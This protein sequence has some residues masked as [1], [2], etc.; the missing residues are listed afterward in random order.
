MQ[1]APKGDP[2]C[3][4]LEA[5]G[6]WVEVQIPY[7]NGSSHSNAATAYGYSGASSGGDDHLKNETFF[8]LIAARTKQLG[9][10]PLYIGADTNV[11]PEASEV[12]KLAVQKGLLIDL[13][14]DW[15]QD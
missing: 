9:T 3:Q 10:N 5:T 4:A 6:R 11:D 8:S 15:C 13:P 1:V 7:G 14:K 2:T 12:L